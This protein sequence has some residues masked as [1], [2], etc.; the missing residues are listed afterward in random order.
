MSQHQDLG[1]VAVLFGGTSSERQISC[2]SGAAVMRALGEQ[3]V[4]VRGFDT[5]DDFLPALL[6]WQPDR[7]FIALH[8]RGGEDG[9]LQ[10]LLSYYQLPF[11]GSGVAASAIAMDKRLSKRIWQGMGLPTARWQEVDHNSS[12]AQ[13]LND[14]GGAVVIK[15]ATEGSSLGIHCVTDEAQWQAAMADAMMYEAPVMAEQLIVGEEYTIGIL[16]D[17]ALPVIRMRA[18]SGFYDYAAKYERND[19]QYDLPCGLSAESE[20]A[21]QSLAMAA[22]QALGCRGWGRIDVMADAAGRF[23]LLEANT[24]PGLT[25]HSLVPKAAAAMGLS[26]NDLVMRLCQQAEVTP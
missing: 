14:L 11:T 24:V 15:P 9:Q 20:R 8:G 10:A 22:H 26:F 21:L 23:Y 5:A 19:T 13:V 2:Q 6:A 1:R 16:A 4:V 12:G 3:Q 17:M 18:A 25:D 7:V